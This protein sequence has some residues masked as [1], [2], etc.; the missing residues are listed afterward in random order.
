MVV[1]SKVGCAK[2]VFGNLIKEGVHKIDHFDLGMLHSNF[3][4]LS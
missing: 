4:S 2:E 3:K 1:V